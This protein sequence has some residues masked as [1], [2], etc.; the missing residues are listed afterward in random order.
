MIDVLLIN[1]RMSYSYN[2]KNKKDII[3]THYPPLGYLYLAA[4]LREKGFKTEVLDTS[5]DLSLKS[6]VN[7]IKR[8][9]PKIIGLSSVTQNIRGCYQLAVEIK[10]KI[11]P[12]PVII[13]G[14]HHISCDSDLVKKYPCFDIGI[15]G[16]GDITLPLIVDK[17]I[18]KKEKIK[19]K[20]FVAELPLDLDKLPMPA[21]DL[22]NIKKIQSKPEISIISSRGCPYNCIFCS[23]P[24]ISKQVRYRSPKL[25]VEEMIDVFKKTGINE[26]AFQDDTFNMN[27]ENVVGICKEIIKSNY[28]FK[29]TAIG[30]F[31]LIDEELVE[32]MA[33][34]GCKK[35][36]FGVES[37]NEKIRNK[38]IGKG[39]TDFQI[40][41]GIRLCKKYDIE[42]FIFLMLGFPGETKKDL[43]ET[44]NFGKKFFPSM[45]GIHI[46]CPLPGSR[47]WNEMIKNGEI[48]PN[49]IDKYM[50][51]NFGEEFDTNWPKLIPK[52]L[53]FDD[54]LK[55]RNKANRNFYLNPR[56]VLK[57]LKKDIFNLASLKEDILEA[58]SVFSHGHSVKVK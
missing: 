45:I 35:F 27:R 10:K 12:S 32:M 24:A 30:R 21:R 57:R 19:N 11:K 50:L 17:I 34:S 26:F 16:E 15:T 22:I 53:T 56:Y 47:L 2:S 29:W 14:G 13:I 20:V 37:G 58:I 23:R 36:M 55:A 43:Y 28:H 39:I 8:K 18:N 33:K 51:G 25:V 42:S 4:E 9:R 1:P 6:I 52:G 48:D 41:E 38:I 49:I 5:N 54:L 3:F 40:R 7:L 44:V 31:N 46:T